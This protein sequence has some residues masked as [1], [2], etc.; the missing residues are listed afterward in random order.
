MQENLARY[1]SIL[2]DMWHRRWLGAAVSWLVALVA[3]A[4]VM[5]T[6]ERYEATSRVYV[7]TQTVLKPLMQGLTVEPDI[8]QMVAM[9]ARTLITRPKLEELIA[10]SHLG[11]GMKDPKDREA[12]IQNL[13]RNIRFASTGGQNLYDIAYR[14]TDRQRALQVAQELVTLFVSSGKGNKT[15]DTEEARRFIDEQIS[16]YEGKLEE[17]ENRLKEFRLKNVGVLGGSDQDY[18][19]RMGSTQQDLAAARVE[20]RAAEESRDALQRQLSS[21]DPNVESGPAPSA[22]PELDARL[23]AQRKQL[24]EL[25]RRY[26]DDH[27]DVISAKRVIS[28]LQEERLRQMQSP[29]GSA[30][31]SAREANPVYQ[32]IKLK[33]ADAEANVASLRG[34]VGELSNRLSQLQ[35]SAERIPKVEAEMAML[36]AQR[37]AAILHNKKH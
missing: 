15:R 30:A 4:V 8:D 31:G 11:D 23:D 26:T 7:D 5:R 36:T 24:D 17:A 27:P 22:T 21:V 28:Q 9:L 13:T 2:R 25:R 20:L 3:A 29:S 33:F 6:P 18:L 32:Q 34:R 35:A 16:V 14:D 1:F 12:L 10:N 19:S 37:I